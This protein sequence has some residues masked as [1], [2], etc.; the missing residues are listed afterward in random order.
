MEALVFAKRKRR[1]EDA[2]ERST[3]C[4]APK[5]LKRDKAN[6]Q[7]DRDGIWTEM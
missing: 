6:I 5:A 4:V 7:G 2:T 1:V 3:E